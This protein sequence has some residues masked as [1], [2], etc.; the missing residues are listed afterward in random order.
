[1]VNGERE[2]AATGWECP[3]TRAENGVTCERSEPWTQE[4]R[5][6]LLE[7]ERLA[8][9]RAISASS[10]LICRPIPRPP[11]YLSYPER[12]AP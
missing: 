1:M 8:G 6:V 7:Q 9:S 2:R 12:G 3:E 5:T 10:N 4:A 11:V